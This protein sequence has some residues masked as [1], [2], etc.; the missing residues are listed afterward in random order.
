[1]IERIFGVF[2]RKFRILRLA[3][4]YSSRTQAQLVTGLGA[5]FNFIRVHDPK[6]LDHYDDVDL[7]PA[8]DTHSYGSLS[9]HI[10]SAEKQRA[11]MRRER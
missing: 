11:D 3:P 10:S 9:T 6:D 2:K 5:V 1:M 8:A 4:E 7:A